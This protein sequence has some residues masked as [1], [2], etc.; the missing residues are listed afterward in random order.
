MELLRRILP[1]TISISALFYLIGLSNGTC[2]IA[3]EAG[4][5]LEIPAPQLQPGFHDNSDT[6]RKAA[7]RRAHLKSSPSGK[8]YSARVSQG[9]KSPSGYE[10]PHRA[11]KFQPYVER[12]SKKFKISSCLIFAVMKAESNFNVTAESPASAYGLMQLVPETGGR[13]AYRMV[14]GSDEIPS[15]E[16]LEDPDRNI[17]LG[18]AYLRLASN[19]FAG[20]EKQ[21]S[22][23]YC[24][25]AAYNTGTGNVIKAFGGG[26]SE[27]IATINSL[28]PSEVYEYLTTYLPSEET[29]IYLAKVLAYRQEFAKLYL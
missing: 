13:A 4:Q 19:Y 27:A 10:L 12:Y 20:V 9:H 22:R 24:Q 11:R 16:Y 18:A 8:L 23:E 7:I 2:H 15:R 6:R 1:I 17:E 3:T 5:K 29:R 25:I 21:L 26:Y 28:T 14:Y